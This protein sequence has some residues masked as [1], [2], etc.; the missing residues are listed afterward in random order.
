[1]DRAT[2]IEAVATKARLDNRADAERAAVETLRTLGRHVSAGEADDLAA[3]LPGEL[4]DAVQ[5][6]SNEDPEELVLAEF[7]RQIAQR[8]G[9]DVDSDAA[10]VHARATMAAIAE[11]GG[12]NALQEAREQLPN[13]F[14]SLFE[15][16]ELA[17]E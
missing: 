17:S 6:A 7:V 4:G 10:M 12:H 11:N 8:E 9:G 15:T 16:D 3:V 2:V 1:M 13:E 14:A 5:A